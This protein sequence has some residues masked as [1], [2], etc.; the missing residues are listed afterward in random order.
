MRWWCLKAKP[1]GDERLEFGVQR[2]SGA[3]EDGHS[4]ETSRN[5][6]DMTQKVANQFA[7][8]GMFR[9]FRPDN[10]SVSH[11]NGEFAREHNVPGTIQANGQR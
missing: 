4:R 5:G 10:K 6:S 11:Q 3:I 1:L 7:K 8:T 9:V 2:Q